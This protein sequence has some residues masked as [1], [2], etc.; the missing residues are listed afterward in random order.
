LATAFSSKVILNEI[1]PLSFISIFLEGIYSI[2][3]STG[4]PVIENSVSALYA[5]KT[6]YLTLKE[7]SSP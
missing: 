3:V 1:S 2:E 4:K 5:E 6:L 7:P